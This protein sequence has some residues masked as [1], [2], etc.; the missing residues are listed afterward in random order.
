L[1]RAKEVEGD[2]RALLATCAERRVEMLRWARMRLADVAR[3]VG[4]DWEKLEPLL[5]DAAQAKRLAELYEAWKP[6]MPKFLSG[7]VRASS[8]WAST[9]STLAAFAE[10]VQRF[11][12]DWDKYLA[13]I[14]LSEINRRRADYNVYY[15]IE[16]AAA[17]DTE[18]IERL[19]FEALTMATVDDL[20]GEFPAG[21]VPVLRGG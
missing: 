17:F 13:G 18:D 9:R 7:D 11:N 20:R 14:D 15:P 1:R 2:W 16:K 19:G 10:S 12:A 21:E 4:G 3:Q 5:D 6:L 8:V